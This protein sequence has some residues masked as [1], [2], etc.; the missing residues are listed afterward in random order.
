MPLICKLTGLDTVRLGVW[1]NVEGDQYFFDHLD[2]YIPEREEVDHL[3]TRKKSEW[4]CSRYLLYQVAGHGLRGACLKDQYGKP[5]I[6]G[7]D[8]FISISHT[9]NYTAVIVSRKVCG[10]D[11]QVIVPKIIPIGVRFINSIELSFIPDDNKLSY[12][13]VIWGA[14]E[15][16]YKCYGKREL[17]FRTHIRVGNFIFDKDGFEFEGEVKKGDYQKNYKIYGRQIDQMILVYALEN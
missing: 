5:F 11:L 7:S 12:Y 1:Q 10:I 14:K 6:H 13:H 16:M 8:E 3:K 9:F 15:A 2:L 17:D 4:L